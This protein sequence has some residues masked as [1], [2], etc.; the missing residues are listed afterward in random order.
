MNEW[1]EERMAVCLLGALLIQQGR[2]G[3]SGW[4]GVS[5]YDLTGEWG[6]VMSEAV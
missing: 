6:T 4:G 3:F 2:R 1:I 5:A